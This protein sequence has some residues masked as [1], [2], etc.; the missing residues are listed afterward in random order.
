M[1]LGPSEHLSWEELAC[2]DGTPY[3]YHWRANGNRIYELATV[4]EYLRILCGG[5]PLKVSSGYRTEQYQR[6]WYESQGKKPRMGSQHIQGRAIDV[7]RPPRI[8]IATL[9]QY[10][11][12]CAS[13]SPYVGGVGY[14]PWG[15]HLDTRPRGASNHIAR[16][17]SN[18]SAIV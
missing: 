6:D 3:P 4:F 1:T 10:A 5:I 9:H 2:S 15:V 12:E 14:Y 13:S 18:E 17:G 11:R 7:H 16:W 8:R